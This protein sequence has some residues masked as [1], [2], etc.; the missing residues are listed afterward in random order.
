MDAKKPPGF[1][2]F[3]S[4][5]RKLVKVPPAALPPKK[6]KPAKRRKKK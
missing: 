5:M 4:L 2:K 1:D 6:R 3:D